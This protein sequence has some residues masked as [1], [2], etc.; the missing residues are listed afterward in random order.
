MLGNGPACVNGGII[1][2]KNKKTL[3]M[4]QEL[5]S[6][7]CQQ[8]DKRACTHLGLQFLEGDRKN[9]SVGIDFLDIACKSGDKKACQIMRS[10]GVAASI[11][12]CKGGIMES[13]YDASRL[14]RKHPEKAAGYAQKGCKAKHWPSCVQLGFFYIQGRGVPQNNAKAHSLFEQ[15]C[16]QK[17]ATG[18]FNLGL[19]FLEGRG[20][21]QDVSQ[22]KKHFQQSCELGDFRGCSHLGLLLRKQGKTQEAS[23]ILQKGCDGG[24]ADN[25][26]QYAYLLLKETPAPLRKAG[27]LFA[28]ACSKGHAKACFNYA[29]MLYQGKGLPRD[30]QKA[31]KIMHRACQLGDEQACKQKNQK[32]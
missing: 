12:N 5:F 6:H 17:T 25:C 8:G 16:A 4:S 2:A 22:A 30:P 21:S 29:V 13:C 18:C 32:K 14:L 11:Q 28:M 20:V 23:K 26:A 24:D 1:A 19:M 7:G 3:A 10:K 9:I 27:A 15:S 31:Q